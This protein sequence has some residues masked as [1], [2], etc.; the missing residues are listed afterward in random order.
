MNEGCL[1]G[2][3]VVNAIQS[4][5]KSLQR[6]GAVGGADCGAEAAGAAGAAPW[7]GTPLGEEEKSGNWRR[8]MSGKV[9]RC[10]KS[11]S[12]GRVSGPR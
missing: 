7:D 8:T 9:A 2:E 4:T 1:R 11:L 6:V 3:W 12:L 10:L 5:G